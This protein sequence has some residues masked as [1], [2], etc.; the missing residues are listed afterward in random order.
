MT[1]RAGSVQRS[2][3]TAP[4]LD[5]GLADALAQLAFAVHAALADC[6]AQEDLSVIQTR[7]LGVLRDRTPTMNELGAH[8]NLDKAS[9]SG[10]IERAQRRGLVTKTVSPTDR[11]SFE[12]A[13]TKTGRK[14]ASRISDRFEAR[15][16]QLVT[17]LS[18]DNRELLRRLAAT[19]VASDHSPTE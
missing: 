2:S 18:T 13:M 12:V 11:R 8:L 17:T 16:D 7:V 4:H 6:A 10:L 5:V 1:S 3:L 9:I 15:I 14:V 19:I